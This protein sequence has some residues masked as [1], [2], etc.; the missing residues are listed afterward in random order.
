MVAIAKCTTCPKGHIC[1]GFGRVDPAI[2]PPGYV[3]S[4]DNLKAPNHRC[5]A[6]FYCPN[7]T[8]TADPFRNDTFLRPYPC[9]P[10]T[11][12]LTGVGFSEVVAG[13]F[14]YAQYC[15][16]G[17][18]CES[19][20]A[21]PRGN[22]LCPKGFVCP[23]GTAIPKPSPKG[24]YAELE[25]TIQAAPCLPGYYSPTIESIVC[26]PCPPGTACEDEGM[27]I[28]NL[29]SP[30]TFR[31]TVTKDG[32]PCKAC[33]QGT[34]SKNYGLR[35]KG[36]CIKCPPGTVCPAESMTTPCSHDDLPMPFEPIVNHNGIPTVEYSF[37][38]YDIN[39]AMYY[40]PAECLRLNEGYI[41][42]R[43]DPISQQYFYGELLPPYID[44]LGRGP[45]FRSVNS[46]FELKFQS[47]VRCYVNYQRFGS[48]IF[49][50]IAD[51]YGPQYDIQFGYD[52]QGY[53]ALDADGLPYYSSFFEVA[54]YSLIYQGQGDLSLPIIVLEV[55]V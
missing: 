5:P 25:G 33:P 55:F 44:I 46:E 41:E 43:M 47:T 36:E 49:Q 37:P 12:C 20:S 34:W 15:T 1:P 19:A 2:C 17:F 42:G 45:N 48:P 10:G 30:G 31:S 8:L 11:Y 51:Y 6:G 22:G 29:C 21:S 52:H 28:A 27:S 18:F 3:C 7:G 4:K 40:S 53:A 26:M 13:D 32:I 9:K 54:H 38:D 50:R 24:Y 35:E 39:A 14:S 16:E 23:L